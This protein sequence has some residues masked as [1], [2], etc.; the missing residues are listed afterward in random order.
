MIYFNDE[1]KLYEQ[2]YEHFK[3]E[4]ESGNLNWKDKLPSRRMLAQNLGVSLNTVKNAYEMLLDE[5]YIVS[6]E[7]VGFFV[8]K[9]NFS[10][11]DE[12]TKSTTEIPTVEE[13]EINFSHA[14]IDLDKLPLSILKKCVTSAIDEIAVGDNQVAGGNLKLR[15]EIVK[16]LK[17]YRGV[18]TDAGNVIITGGYT[19]NLML[20]LNLLDNPIFA[21]EDPGYKKVFEN[22]VKLSS[23][24]HIPLDKYGFSVAELEKTDANVAVVTPNHQFPTGKIM[25]L[26]RKQRLLNWAIEKHDRYIIEDDYDGDFKYIGHPIASIKSMDKTD[27]VIISGSFSKTIGKFLKISF[28]VLPEELTDRYYQIKNMVQ[29]PSMLQQE[30]LYRFMYQKAFEKHLNRMNV[31]YKK[32]RAILIKELKK[33]SGLEI[34]GADAGTYFV[35]TFKEDKFDIEKIKEEFK[36]KKIKVNFVSEYSNSEDYFNHMIVGFGGIEMEK[37]ENAARE[38]AEII[39]Q[40]KI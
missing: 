25:V 2:I 21:V 20:L 12:K 13:V 3:N 7:R 8:D 9:L 5:G 33:I 28:L 10:K 27:R 17:T 23:V 4:I 36:K 18:D 37:I 19:D 22:T 39:V 11:R 26:R 24:H 34:S 31:C 30:T 14:A 15:Q 29:V 16:Y 1:K 38:L 40:N 35:I 32:K 6:D